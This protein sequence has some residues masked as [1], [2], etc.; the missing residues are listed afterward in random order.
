MPYPDLQTL[1]NNGMGSFAAIQAGTQQGE[2]QQKAAAAAQMQQ[3]L[4]QEQQLKNQQTQAM[5]PLDLMFRQGQVDTQKAQLGG[6]QANSDL[7]RTNADTASATQASAIASAISKS[8]TQIG[9][10][11]MKRM[12]DDASKAVQVAALLDGVP[13]MQ[14]GA[15]FQSAMEKYGA[16]VESPFIQSFTKVPPEKLPD[17]LRAMGQGMAMA[18]EDYIKN[19]AIAKSKQTFE[20]AEGDKD[21]ANRLSI[22]GGNNA[23]TLEAARIGATSRENVAGTAAQARKFMAQNK[24]K[25]MDQLI[26]G[27]TAIPE[28]ERTEDEKRSLQEAQTQR[29][30]ERAAGANPLAAQMI[31]G[32]QS[33]QQIAAQGGQIAPQPGA[34]APT[35]P[36]GMKQVGTSGGRPVYEDAQGKR[37]TQ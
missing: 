36:A 14:R 2:E 30:K 10:D 31:P 34:Q 20:A 11:G 23:T 3:Q 32:M 12:K 6:V 18:S 15:A 28:S 19:A 24:P 29:L 13:P 5:N 27:L 26:A 4:L 22:A 8:A 1:F 21:R 37:Y 9:E 16:N 33:P 7:A 25:S 35:A 17:Q